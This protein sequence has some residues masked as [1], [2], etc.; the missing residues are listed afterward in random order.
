M[1]SGVHATS[2]GIRAGAGSLATRASELAARTRAA[3]HA[4]RPPKK[5]R[6]LLRGTVFPFVRTQCRKLIARHALQL[7]AHVVVPRTAKLPANRLV[8]ARVGNH[9]L[10]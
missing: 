4:K 9:E 5:E 2:D 6:P 8:L 10:R 1:V 3:S 7:R